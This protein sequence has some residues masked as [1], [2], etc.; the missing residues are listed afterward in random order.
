VMPQPGQTLLA[1]TA[2]RSEET[3]AGGGAEGGG[4]EQR[5]RRRRIGKGL[6]VWDAGR[7]GGGGRGEGVVAGWTRRRRT[8]WRR[9]ARDNISPRRRSRC[10][11][12]GG[13]QPLRLQGVGRKSEQKKYRFGLK[14]CE[15]KVGFSEWAF[16]VRYRRSGPL[17]VD[18]SDMCWAR[19]ETPDI[20]FFFFS[21]K[22]KGIS[23][24]SLSKTNVL[25]ASP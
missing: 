12:D 6:G 11:I 18:T 23:F 21:Q 25:S 14:A 1:A 5:W 8:R 3:T 20:I 4:V 17:T 16:S 19:C 22:E 15:I 2:G 10:V 7:C 13:C 9:R 24:A